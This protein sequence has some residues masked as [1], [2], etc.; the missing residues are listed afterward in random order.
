VF[1]RFFKIKAEQIFDTQNFFIETKQTIFFLKF[2]GSRRNR[3]IKLITF[4]DP[5]E[6]NQELSK[7]L[8][9]KPEGTTNFWS[10]EEHALV[11]QS[12]LG[13]RRDKSFCS[14]TFWIEKEQTEVFQRF[15][16]GHTKKQ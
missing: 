1:A 8:G 12:F 6:T 2:S 3:P 7:V 11:F 5:S 15:S 9:L 16:G 13:T 4:E 10:K 14:K